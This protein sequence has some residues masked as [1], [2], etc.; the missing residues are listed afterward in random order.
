VLAESGKVFARRL[1]DKPQVLA[2]SPWN[3]KSNS[4]V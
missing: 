1:R 4:L 2:A 3:I